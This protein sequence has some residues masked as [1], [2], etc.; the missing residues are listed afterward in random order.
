MHER[1]T[2]KPVLERASADRE[3]YLLAQER[4]ARVPHVQPCPVGG[5]AGEGEGGAMKWP[6]VRRSKYA[7][8]VYLARGTAG[9]ILELLDPIDR[10]N[11]KC[12]WCGAAG[13]MTSPPSWGHVAGC[14]GVRRYTAGLELLYAQQ[15]RHD[16]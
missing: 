2:K 9:G 6:F 7:A 3:E 10:V 14:E 5:A 1:T 15:R 13:S 12:L 16:V 4:D 11:Q 8:M